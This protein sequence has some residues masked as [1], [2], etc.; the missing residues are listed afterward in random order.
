MHLFLRK[1]LLFITLL[2]ISYFSLFILIALSTRYT[3]RGENYTFGI[4]TLWGSTYQ[5]SIDMNNWMLNASHQKHGLIIGP[6]TAYRNINPLM[7]DTA[8]GMD[9]FNA[10]SSAQ[11]VAMSFELLKKISGSTKID[12]VLLD[13]FPPITGNN[14]YESATDWVLNSSAGITDR[15]KMMKTTQPDI[16]LINQAIYRS[17]KSK[18]GGKNYFTPGGKNGSYIAK[19]FVCSDDETGL[20]KMP[21]KSNKTSTTNVNSKLLPIIQYCKQHSI[22]LI[23][24]IAPEL[25]ATTQVIDNPQNATVLI[26]DDFIT[27]GTEAYQYYYDSHHLTCTGSTVYTNYLISKIKKVLKP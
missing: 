17:I 14:G 20:T 15:F 6:S 7:L 5:R 21:A 10:G 16:K 22:Q 13:V 18:I 11:S 3:K 2:L 1:I 12:V 4:N 27:S 8:T 19:G 9:W 26:N 23:I 24:N 25:N